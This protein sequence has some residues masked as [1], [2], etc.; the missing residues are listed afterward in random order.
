MRTLLAATLLA[1]TTIVAAAT[2]PYDELADAKADIHAAL[3]QARSDQMPVLVVFG[4]NWYGD[5]RVLDMAFKEGTA[6]PLIAKKFKVVKVNVGRFDQNVD[7]AEAYGLSL[8]RGIPAVVVLSDQGKV[9]YS[10]SAGELANARK[11]GDSGIYAFFNKMA[12]AD[13]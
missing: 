13:R 5:C 2:L 7:V 3:A 11:M 4:A 1:A 8:R 10:T 6:A 12:L 9:V